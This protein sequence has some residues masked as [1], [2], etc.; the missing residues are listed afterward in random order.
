[1]HPMKRYVN[2]NPPIIS[3]ETA[4]EVY[5]ICEMHRL[6]NTRPGSTKVDWVAAQYRIGQ[7]GAL[8]LITEAERVL[9][10]ERHSTQL[11]PATGVGA[12]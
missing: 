1:M 6:T 9:G 8:S 10:P 2:W 5:R 4:L 11:P 7:L 12:L 3:R